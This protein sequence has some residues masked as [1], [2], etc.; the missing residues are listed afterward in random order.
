MWFCTLFALI[1]DRS[2]GTV[3]ATPLCL[4]WRPEDMAHDSLTRELAGIGNELPMSCLWVAYELPWRNSLPHSRHLNEQCIVIWT[5][6]TSSRN[7]YNNYMY[8]QYYTIVDIVHIYTCLLMNNS[9][10]NA[11]VSDTISAVNVCYVGGTHN[12]SW[13]LA[14][15]Q[16]H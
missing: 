9:Y 3:D 7:R 2:G 12:Q 10:G 14:S 8:C 5:Q 4:H 15:P 11:I 13:L 6:D 1:G 16:S